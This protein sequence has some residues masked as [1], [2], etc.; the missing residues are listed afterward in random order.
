[1]RMRPGGRCSHKKQID[2]QFAAVFSIPRCKLVGRVWSRCDVTPARCKTHLTPGRCGEHVSGLG[3]H[4]QP[5]FTFLHLTSLTHTTSARHIFTCD[6]NAPLHLSIRLDSLARHRLLGC[7]GSL[8]SLNPIL[9][10]AACNA[11]SPL[12]APYGERLP[13]RSHRENRI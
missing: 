1:M 11:S 9:Q 7:I 2:V 12:L 8:V 4:F 5:P 3:P 13:A 6:E 10:P